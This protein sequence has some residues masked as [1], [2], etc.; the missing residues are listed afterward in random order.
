MAP[1]YRLG[2]GPVTIRPWVLSSCGRNPPMVF[3]EDRPP[4]DAFAER[5]RELLAEA[6]ASGVDV[7]GGWPAVNEDPD[8]P[9][10]DVVVVELA[11]PD[12]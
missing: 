11:R 7:R 12:Q 3:D 1:A 6:H 10:W 8:L 5:L 2:T 9:D 4:D